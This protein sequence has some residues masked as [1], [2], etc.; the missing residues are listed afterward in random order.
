MSKG[1]SAGSTLAFQRVSGLGCKL[2][3]N[4]IRCTNMSQAHITCLDWPLSQLK[5]N[6]S[7]L[8]HTVLYPNNT[9]PAT[10]T[11]CKSWALRREDLLA[12]RAYSWMA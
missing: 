3:A 4:L 10:S 8:S 9:T 2:G 1:N 6:I 11:P 7:H 5:P 12:R